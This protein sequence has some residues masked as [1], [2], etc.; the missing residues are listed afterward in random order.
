MSSGRARV[1]VVTGA[2]G[3]LGIALVRSLVQSGHHVAALDRSETGL[4]AA[5]ATWTSDGVE[6]FHT[7]VVDQTDRRQVDEAVARAVM[8]HGD[9]V[10]VVANAGYAKFGSFLT[11]ESR[12]WQRHVDVNLNGTFDVCQAVA[13]QLA[14]QRSGGWMTV[15]SSGLALYHSDQVSAYCTTKAALLTMVRSAAAELGVHRIRVN[16]ILPGVIDTAMTHGML[17]EAGART[18]VLAKTPMGRLGSVDDITSLV[19]FLASSRAEW[20]T[21]S[22]ML[23]DG[24]QSLYGQPTWMVQ[25]RRTPHEPAWVKGYQAP[26]PAE[27]EQYTLLYSNL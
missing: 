23:V 19:D 15:V 1:A 27:I 24:G 7:A 3:S 4:E 14:Q 10:G 26:E 25:D 11:M 9:L 8:D 21:G 6:D 22:S 12:D 20:I 17:E 5:A 2:A 18:G 13:R 16:A